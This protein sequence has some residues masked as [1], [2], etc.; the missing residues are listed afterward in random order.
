VT[1]VTPAL[2][3][4]KVFRERLELPGLR[5]LRAFRVRLEPLARRERLARRVSRASRVS[6]VFRE[7]RAR[8]AQRVP[9]DLLARRVRRVF[10]ANRARA[11]RPAARPVRFFLRLTPLITT[12][13]GP[14]RSLLFLALP[15]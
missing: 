3:V 8:P 6:R 4:S 15:T 5:G 10:K 12:R 2:R 14:T 9:K 11:F 7:S 13:R 1:L